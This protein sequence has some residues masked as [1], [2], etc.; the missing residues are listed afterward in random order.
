MQPMLFQFIHLSLFQKH[1][2]VKGNGAD[3]QHKALVETTKHTLVHETN[4][5]TPHEFRTWFEE[6]DVPCYKTYKSYVQ[7]LYS[8]FTL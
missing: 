5:N 8:I 1:D 3:A 6:Y 2:V 7:A 4:M